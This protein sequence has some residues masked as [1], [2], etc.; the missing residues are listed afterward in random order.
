MSNLDE[1]AL[2]EKWF[3]LPAAAASS[4]VRLTPPPPG[5]VGWP[6]GVNDA[7]VCPRHRHRPTALL[8]PRG[9]GAAAVASPPACVH[10]PPP[11]HRTAAS[12]GYPSKPVGEGVTGVGGEELRPSEHESQSRSQGSSNC[13][14]ILFDHVN[15]IIRMADN[16]EDSPT[17]QSQEKCEVSDRVYTFITVLKLQHIS[18]L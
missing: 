15:R 18:S 9:F 17:L 16:L 8:H 12:H 11:D 1:M 7:A 5:L 3:L 13:T 4:R 2:V 10:R 6:K 14:L